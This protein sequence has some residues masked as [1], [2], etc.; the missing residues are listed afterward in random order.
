VRVEGQPAAY[1][2][3]TAGDE[4]LHTPSAAPSTSSAASAA[5][6]PA[7]SATSAPANRPPNSP[8]SGV[9]AAGMT[10]GPHQL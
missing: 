1:L 9:S 4:I 5:T 10:D 6:S 2:N 7:K 8:R 3:G